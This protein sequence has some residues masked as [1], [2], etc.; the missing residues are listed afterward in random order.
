M[1]TETVPQLNLKR[2]GFVDA[3]IL[4]TKDY[5]YKIVFSHEG[6][7]VA[8]IFHHTEILNLKDLFI[9]NNKISSM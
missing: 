7:E 2:Y 3:E 1:S 6:K 5:L 8:E 9:Q 4:W